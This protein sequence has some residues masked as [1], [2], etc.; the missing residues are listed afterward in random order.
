MKTKLSMKEFNALARNDLGDII[1]LWEV[2]HI[3]NSKQVVLLSEDDSSR[4]EDY[5]EELRILLNDAY[6]EFA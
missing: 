2:F 4:Y 5:Q 3:L 1:N 6:L